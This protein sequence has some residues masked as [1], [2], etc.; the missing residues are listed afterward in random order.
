MRGAG[1]T[2][3]P[4]EAGSPARRGT[5][6]SLAGIVA[7][8]RDGAWLDR[9]RVRIGAV[10]LLGLQAAVFAFFVA[11][12][13]GWIVNLAGP[14]TTDFVSFYAAGK[15]ADAGTPALAYDHAAH[16]AAEEQVTGP[17]IGYQ[18]FNYPPVYLLP[19][20]ALSP[21]PYLVAFVI[22]ET[23][24][25]ALYLVVTTRILGER[26]ATA[27]IALIAFPIVFWN[28]GLGQNAFLTAALFGA[29]TLLIDCRPV[30]AG[31]LFGALCYK[32]QFGL[33]VPLALAAAGR[34]RAVAAAAAS[35]AGLVLLSLA[36]FGAATWRDFFAVA[37]GSHAMYASGRILFAGMANMF[38]A[39]RLLGAGVPLA[40]ALQAVASLVAAAVVVIVWRRGLALPIRAATLAAATLV[41]APLALFYDLMLGA[42]AAAWLIRDADSPAAAGWEKIAL[43]A[44]YLVLLHGPSRGEQ[45]RIPLF[46]LAALALF[47]IVVARAWREMSLRPGAASEPVPTEAPLSAGAPPN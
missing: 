26:S 9:K 14:T 28:F 11:G 44:F 35:V 18:F 45:W 20:A 24:T 37:G 27:L 7:R 38:G 2:T 19:F 21:L 39:A 32:P 1:N 6:A 33:L 13:H 43:A 16:L 42:V 34:W 3:R 5:M 36:L 8:L 41:A 17:G 15:L 47:A 25:L 12:T 29:A 30:A 4:D 22:F 40:Y 46:P 10:I 31:L 23:V